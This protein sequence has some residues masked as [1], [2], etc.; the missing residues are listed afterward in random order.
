[1]YFPKGLLLLIPNYVLFSYELINLEVVGF[2][3]LPIFWYKS[4]IISLCRHLH[5]T[6]AVSR[7]SY[8]RRIPFGVQSDSAQLLN[9]HLYFPQISIV[10]LGTV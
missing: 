5:R 2:G 10:L 8:E 3:S 1:M 7:T 9:T 4:M 6:F